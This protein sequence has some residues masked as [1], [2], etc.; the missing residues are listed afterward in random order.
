MKNVEYENVS[1]GL[2]LHRQSSKRNTSLNL[3]ID[4]SQPLFFPFFSLPL[5]QLAGKGLV[6][7]KQS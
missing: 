3:T 4:A 5:S 7:R 1:L 6:F 2:W